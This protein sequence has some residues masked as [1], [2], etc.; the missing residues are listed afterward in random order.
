MAPAYRALNGSVGPS[1]E[2]SGPVPTGEA[3]AGRDDNGD[4]LGNN[5]RRDR[6]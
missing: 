5:S 6:Q 2:E 1:E 4:N 3:V